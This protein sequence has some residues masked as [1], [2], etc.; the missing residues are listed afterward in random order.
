MAGIGSSPSFRLEYDIPGGG[1]GQAVNRFI[2]KLA[3]EKKFEQ[4]LKKLKKLV[5]GNAK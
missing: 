1:I 2:I 5:E 3:N 4:C